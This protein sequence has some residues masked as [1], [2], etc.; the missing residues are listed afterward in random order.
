MRQKIIICH[1]DLCGKKTS[2]NNISKASLT[3]ENRITNNKVFDIDICDDC[4]QHSFSEVI[5]KEE[6]VY[7]TKE[8]FKRPTD[9][10]NL[11]K[12]ICSCIN[13]WN[14]KSKVR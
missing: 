14:K 11:F 5:Q 8:S 10:K 3:F 1:C 13:S 12:A 2:E 4:M 7:E 9:N 6:N